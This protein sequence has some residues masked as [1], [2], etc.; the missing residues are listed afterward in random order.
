[1]ARYFACCFRACSRAATAAGS[2][3][4]RHPAF[5]SAAVQP[6]AHIASSPV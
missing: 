4:V 3:H 5:A 1:M 6:T 2:T